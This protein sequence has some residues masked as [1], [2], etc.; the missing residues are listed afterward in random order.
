MNISRTFAFIIGFPILIIIEII[1]YRKKKSINYRE[2]CVILLSIYFMGLISVTL[3]PIRTMMR[4]DPIINIIPVVNTIKSITKLSSDMMSYS[5]KFWIINIIG[6]LFLLAPIAAIVPIIF[7]KFRNIR[8]TLILCFLISILIEFLQY[9]SIYFG[10]M[11]SVDIDDVIL[12]TLGSLLGFLIFKRIKNTYSRKVD[13]NLEEDKGNLMEILRT[14]NLF[15]TYGED[16]REVKALKSVNFSVNK[17]EFIAV[18]GP[19]GSGK[20]TLLHLLGGMDKPSGGKVIIQGT[21]IY[22]LKEK[23]LSSFRV[24]K[25]GFV[26]QLFNLLPMMTAEENIILPNLIDKKKIDKNY[27]KKILEMLSIEDRLD[28]YPSQLSG[29]QQQRVA[30]GRAL[31]NKPS[32]IL[33]DEPTGNLDSKTSSEILNLL[34]YSIKEFN[35]T[36]I[37]ITHDVNIAKHADRILVMEDGVLSEKS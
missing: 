28:Y 29:G 32:I 24:R 35:Q 7:K 25:I 14:E 10:N 23:E 19:S 2:I 17:G 27:L 6:N 15:K 4:L 37:M 11:R 8:S 21:D 16:D 1:R 12:N 20:S 31:S 5:I 22:A 18:L 9:L 36:L 34:K 33:A 26:F 30:I 13:S 3:L